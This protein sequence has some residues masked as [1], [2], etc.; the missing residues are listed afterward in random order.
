[1][2]WEHFG[3]GKEKFQVDHIKAL[4]LFDL[5]NPAE[6]LLANH[7]SNLQPLWFNEHN[8]K[9]QNDLALNEMLKPSVIESLL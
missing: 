1:M 4:C 3:G 9:S 8:I 6:Q 2:S 7:Y 5:Q